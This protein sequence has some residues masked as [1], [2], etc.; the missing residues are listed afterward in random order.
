MNFLIIGI[1][2]HKTPIEVRE[3]LSFRDTDV[4]DITER[5]CNNR[6]NE[7]LV[8]STCN[9][10]EI[11]IYSD[12]IKPEYV[13]KYLSEHFN[14]DILDEYKL[15]LS[16]VE[17]LRHL[18]FLCVG[19]D[20][21]VVG[22]DQILG[23]VS[24]AFETALSLGGAKKF[25]SKFFREAINFAKNVKCDS[26]VS[27]I[28]L[29]TAYL[30][31]KL[32]EQ[33]INLYKK[34]ALVIGIGDMGIL[35]YKYLRERGSE[36]YISNR[37]YE[38]SKKIKTQDP[39]VVIVDYKEVKKNLGV[40]D[41]IVLA[42]AAPHTILHKYNLDGI[43]KPI[44][45]LDLSLPRAADKEIHEIENIT[46][47]DIDSINSVASVNAEKK[48]RILEKYIPYIEDKL[49]ELVKWT[50]NSDFDEVFGNVKGYAD[51]VISDTCN[52]IERKTN[53]SRH[54]MRK[55]AKVVS[56]AV[57]KV[58][59]EPL[60]CAREIE[61]KETKKAVMNFFKEIYNEDK[62]RDQGE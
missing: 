39:D 13:W 5:F 10:S 51:K 59:H 44:V 41:L 1:N 37:T 23:Q 36:I 46:I 33:K 58:Y 14:V 22:E 2:H 3:K 24:N 42:T 12:D 60:I 6:T 26:N 15:E 17:A 25:L 45:I 16:G 62:D 28:P 11:Y 19:L 49:N 54:E 38:K 53:L 43:V 48:R 50:E 31:V 29:S 18:F 21:M 52:Y 35:A 47:F 8:L 9:R 32:V 40:Y 20:S 56:F 27:D 30:G 55:V 7:L 4:I 34:K 57:N 61:D